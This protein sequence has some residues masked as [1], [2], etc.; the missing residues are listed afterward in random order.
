MK[1]RHLS[2]FSMGVGAV[3][4][5]TSAD[6]RLEAIA[7]GVARAQEAAYSVEATPMLTAGKRIRVSQSDLE[8][9]TVPKPGNCS[10][11]SKDGKDVCQTNCK[12]GEVAKCRDGDPPECVCQ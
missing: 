12:E 4:A 3:L 10:A 7:V 8:A 2:T 5:L 1:Y 11:S 6:P 9:T